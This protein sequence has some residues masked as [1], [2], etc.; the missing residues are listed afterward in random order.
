MKC[1]GNHEIPEC[2]PDENLVIKCVNCSE[3]H[4]E[5]YSGFRFN[6][7][8]LKNN[9]YTSIRNSHIA[10]KRKTTLPNSSYS[11]ITKNV[12]QPEIPPDP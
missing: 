11:N 12:P 9:G 3:T 1:A 8:N 2:P 7:R 6:P 5:N 10:F 4:T